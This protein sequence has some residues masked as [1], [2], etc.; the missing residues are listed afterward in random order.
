MII[1]YSADAAAIVLV[2][3]PIHWHCIGHQDN[4]SSLKQPPDKLNPTLQ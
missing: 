2:S 4:F 3:P 1:M